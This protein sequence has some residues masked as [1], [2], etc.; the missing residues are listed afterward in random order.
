V[1]KRGDKVPHL[2][3][4]LTLRGLTLRNRI[5]MAPMCQYSTGPD[6]MPT[7]WHYLHYPTRAVGGAGLIMVESTVVDRLGQTD[8]THLGIYDP[9]HVPALK[10]LTDLCHANGAPVGL[11]IV[12]AGRK[13][14]TDRKGFGPTQPVAPSALPH[15][16][17]WNVPRAL[18]KE[19]ID[20]AVASF[21]RAARWAL[22]AGFDVLEIHAAHGYLITEF[23]SPLS[24]HRDD[25]YGGSAENRLRFFHEV[26]DA[27]RREWPE[28]M[29]LF[30]RMS[31]TEWVPGGLDVEQSIAI[32]STL[33]ERGVDLVDVSTEV[34]EPGIVDVGPG[35]QTPFAEAIR[36]G[37]G[38]P[39]A[40]VGMI[41]TAE[42]A[43]EI[44]RNGRADL[45]AMGKELMRNPYF[46]LQAATELG[47]EVEWPVQY[48]RA[49]R[50]YLR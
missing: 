30:A 45:V 23:L 10:R 28:R 18:T 13:A 29:P 47:H 22:E 8:D 15:A 50:K 33:A 11:Q 24:N 16:D 38:I 1:E 17:G 25:E 42:L 14:W 26:I 39:T 32:A 5:M 48:R 36:K 40:A 49:R 34:K 12:H 44:I 21:A 41:T 35:Y 3:E 31:A 7:D 27:V 43:N 37:A 46:P 20:Q 6:S 9:A 19:G 4:P 2:F